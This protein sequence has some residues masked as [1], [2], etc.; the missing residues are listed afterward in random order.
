MSEEFIEKNVEIQNAKT[1]VQ[2]I[3]KQGRIN[4]KNSEYRSGAGFLPKKL[5]NE[6]HIEFHKN[7]DKAAYKQKKVGQRTQDIR[8]SVIDGFFRDLWKLKFKVESI[9]SLKPKHLEAVFHFLEEQGQSPSTIQN[10]ISVM[11]VFCG[12]IGKGGMVKDS[13]FYV[14]SQA[15]VTRSMVVKED[16]SWD[17]SGV[18]VIER[19]KEVVAIDVN[20]AMTLE[21]CWVFGLRVKEAIMLR[22]AVAHN[23]DG[24]L[25]VREG[26]KGD[27]ERS[28]PIES[29]IQREVLERAKLVADKKTGFL[30]KRGKTVTQKL[31]RFYYV[32]EKCGITLNEAKVTAHGLRH[33]YMH[34]SY[35]KLLGDVPPVKGGDISKLDKFKYHLATQQLSE[36]AGHTRVTISSAYYGSRRVGKMTSSSGNNLSEK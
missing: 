7:C 9:C 22:P 5:H 10:K 18:D 21:L 16:K 32:M 1:T 19:L 14:K 15:S 31:R 17:G 12:W 33:Q 8:R 20:V 23:A 25:V 26:T 30:G 4:G 28:I 11:R 36:R 3:S 34:D 13:S 35:I 24:V 6:I 2:K 27:R 29:D